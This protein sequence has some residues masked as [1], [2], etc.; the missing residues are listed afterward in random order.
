M[1]IMGQNP[2]LLNFLGPDYLEQPR[3]VNLT[4]I[5]KHYKKSFVTVE[6]CKNARPVVKRNFN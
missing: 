1:K 6:S 3:A 4:A 2:H 5:E